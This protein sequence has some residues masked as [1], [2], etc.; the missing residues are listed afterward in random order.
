MGIVFLAD[1]HGLKQHQELISAISGFGEVQDVSKEADD[2]VALTH[3]ACSRMREG[4]MA[5]LI[6]GTGQGT[7]IVANKHKGIRAARCLSTQDAENAKV[8]NNA[9]VLCLSAE[10]DLKTN[11]EIIKAFL[12]TAY[13]GR[14]P[15]R[16]EA[17]KALETEQFKAK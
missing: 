9:N 8:I 11:E 6:C 17:I 16:L 1:Q 5:V 15:E 2:Y 10:T 12:T 3:L 7:A 13:E 4:D 14:K